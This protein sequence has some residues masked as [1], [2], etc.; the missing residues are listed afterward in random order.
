MARIHPIQYDLVKFG[1][2]HQSR[3]AGSSLSLFLLLFQRS[4]SRHLARRQGSRLASCPFDGA[5][6]F[7]ASLGQ[8]LGRGES[9]GYSPACNSLFTSLLGSSALAPHSSLLPS[10]VRPG[11]YMRVQAQEGIHV[12][13]ITRRVPL[14]L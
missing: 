1:A 10:R 2:H 12:V 9:D 4:S 11:W 5:A 3:L 14:C 6:R 8:G 13:Y 7:A